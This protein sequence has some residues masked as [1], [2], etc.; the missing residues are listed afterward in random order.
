MASERTIEVDLTLHGV[1][2][3]WAAAG[4]RSRVIVPAGTPVADVLTRAGLEPDDRFLILIDGETAQASTILTG[5]KTI[6][7]SVFPR[8]SGGQ[9]KPPGE[10]GRA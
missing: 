3:R 5:A 6:A 2:S 10:G 9:S 8:I 1:L 7:V 4:A